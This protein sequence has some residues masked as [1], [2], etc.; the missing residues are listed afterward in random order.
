MDIVSAGVGTYKFV[1]D[2]SL[3]SEDMADGSDG[4]VVD[5]GLL[6]SREEGAKIST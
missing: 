3:A 6:A 2:G 1:D 5:C 4:G